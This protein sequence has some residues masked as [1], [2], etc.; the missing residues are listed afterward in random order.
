MRIAIDID[1]VVANFT[2]RMGE[3]FNFS[4]QDLH[5]WE[6]LPALC[7]QMSAEEFHAYLVSDE[8]KD[9]FL[10]LEV[11]DWDVWVV[12]DQLLE[13]GHDLMFVTSRPEEVEDVTS[14]WLTHNRMGDIPVVFAQDK[15]KV[16]EQFDVLIDD[17]P[18]HIWAVNDLDGKHAI[19]FDR[20]WN[21]N[22]NTLYPRVLGWGDVI[23]LID[24]LEPPPP[25]LK[26]FNP[27]PYFT[28]EHYQTYDNLSYTPPP[29][30]QDSGEVRVVNKTTGGQKGSKLER[31]DLI[32]T[33]PLAEVARHYGRGARKYD[34]HNWRRGYDWSLSYAALQ[35]HAQA[36]WDGEDIDPETGSH[37][38]AAVVFH[39]LAMMEWGKTHPELDDRWKDE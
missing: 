3:Q 22:V 19:V 14:E 16:S 15:A 33:G 35:R 24:W 5:A 32:P 10:N 9:M 23:E 21:R 28:R 29:V 18:D 27:A 26:P 31:Y 8:G 11:L 37:H 39:A 2:G 1:D 20:P 13:D 12:I 17:N 6:G 38:L 30:I 7:G 4:P 36:F 34:D 25:S